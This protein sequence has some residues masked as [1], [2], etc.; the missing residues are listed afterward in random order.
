MQA[1]QAMRY[2]P[3]GLF[4]MGSARFYPEEAP[5]R[6][7]RVDAFL[8]DEVPVTN[9]AFA[10][11]VAATGHLTVAETPLRA[12]DYPGLA[13]ELAVAGSAV[14]DVGAAAR[15]HV[16]QWHFVA[17]ADW[18][19]PLGPQSNLE[20]LDDHPVV[21]VAHADA[22]VYA[23]WA[24]KEL[25][26]EAQWECAAR[27]GLDDADYA[28]GDELA[29]A[30]A[31]LANYWQGPFPDRNDRLDGWERTSPVRSFAA[32]PFGLHDLIGNVWEWTEDWWSL[33]VAGTAPVKA[34]C[35]PANP[36]GGPETGSLDPLQATRVPRKVI[37]GGSHLC[38]ENFCR[39]YRPA[40]RHPQAIDS[41]T[42]HI[43]FR[44][45]APMSGY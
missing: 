42:S 25:P 13:P 36:R 6:R 28:W 9:A 29:P 23:R 11:F 20:G 8:M 43:G 34:C 22:L 7:V 10:A 38:A 39:R 4:T 18:R 32:N 15:G 14:F 24:G 35:I 21:H 30:G 12:E 1:T 45:V 37:K 17:G 27:G 3:G 33:P 19:H 2:V 41:P 26:T 16:P 40:A 31:M 5:P 44:C